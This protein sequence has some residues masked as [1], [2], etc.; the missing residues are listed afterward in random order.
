MSKLQFSPIDQAFSL[1]SEQIRDRQ[2][3]IS[4]LKSLILKSSTGNK[5][6]SSVPTPSKE[7]KP[8]PKEPSYERI[9]KPDKV[10][11]TFE[12]DDDYMFY[13]M[14]KHPKFDE[15]VK[16]YIMFKHPEW[17]LKQTNYEPSKSTFGQMYSSTAFSEIKKY[18]IFFVICIVIF[19]SLSVY[20][21]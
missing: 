7:E 4:D 9:G 11:A 6:E 21:K 1:S 12:P 2:K 19:T 10:T 20:L 14:M 15:I 8:L 5:E 17:G 18:I 16:N 13:R 3:E